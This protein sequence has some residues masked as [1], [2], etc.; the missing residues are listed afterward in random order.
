MHPKTKAA[1]L[2]AALALS[3]LLAPLAAADPVDGSCTDPNATECIRYAEAEGKWAVGYGADTAVWAV[4]TGASYATWAVGTAGDAAEAA[5]CI[6][7]TVLGGTCPEL[8]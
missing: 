4:D 6:V 5:V 3:V 1:S 8:F 2:F 7:I